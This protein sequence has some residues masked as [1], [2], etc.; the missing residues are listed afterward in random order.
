MTERQLLIERV[1][2]GCEFPFCPQN[3]YGNVYYALCDSMNMNN[4]DFKTFFPDLPSPMFHIYKLDKNKCAELSILILE[5]STIE[6]LQKIVSH[7]EYFANLQNE[8]DYDDD[9]FY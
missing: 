9:E 4:D 6:V 1:Y 3:V 7:I 8:D 5:K 2:D